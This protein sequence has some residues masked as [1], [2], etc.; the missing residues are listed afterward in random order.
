M[1]TSSRAVMAH[2]SNAAQLDTWDHADLRSHCSVFL[3]CKVMIPLIRDATALSSV[4]SAYISDRSRGRELA[5]GS[6]GLN[7]FVGTSPGP[8]A[9]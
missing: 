9:G 2:G 7:R 6:T 1:F 4:T 3:A 5:R 8:P